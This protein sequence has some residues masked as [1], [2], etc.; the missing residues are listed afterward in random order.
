M[1]MKI[2]EETLRWFNGDELRARVFYEKYALRDY[3]GNVVEKIPPEMWKRVAREIASVELPE[4]RQDWE[5]KFYSILENF[6]FVPGGRIMFG[7]GNPRRSTLLNCYYIPIKEDSIEGIFECAKEMARTY[8][9]G[10]G[11]GCVAKD[12]YVVTRSGLKNIEKVLEGEEVLSFDPKLH[13][14]EFRKVIKTHRVIVKKEDNVK[15]KL[16]D[17]TELVTSRWH[18]TLVFRDGKFVYVPAEEV[19]IGDMMLRTPKIHNFPINV[20]YHNP[21]LGWIAGAYISDMHSIEAKTKKKINYSSLQSRYAYKTTGMGIQT[22]VPYDVHQWKN[23]NH[24][25]SYREDANYV[26]IVSN[27]TLELGAV[28]LPEW[29]FSSSY[30]TQIAFI[31]GVVDS[32]GKV[33]NSGIEIY[34]SDKSLAYDLKLLIS[35]L[36]GYADILEA[37]DQNHHA[38][39]SYRIRIKSSEFILKVSKYMKH[40]QKALNIQDILNNAEQNYVYVPKFIKKFILS[41]LT[42]NKDI[43]KILSSDY[44]GKQEFEKII[45]ALISENTNKSIDLYYTVLKYRELCLSLVQVENIQ[46]AVN[47]DEEFCDLTVEKNNNYF[48]GVGGLS[49]IHN[50][51]ISILRPKGSPVNNSAIYSTGA[52]SFMDLFSKVTGT[53]GQCLAKGT[54]VLTS[55]GWK[56]IEDI[57]VGDKVWTNKGWKKVSYVFEKRKTKLYKVTTNYGYTITASKDHK[58][59]DENFKL[60]PLGE[61]KEGD[62]VTMIVGCGTDVKTYPKLKATSTN[63]TG[64]LEYGRCSVK[65]PKILDTRL[66]YWLGFFSGA[67]SLE[68]D[69]KINF[70]FS[71]NR[72]DHI[73]IKNNLLKVTK[74]LFGI[75]PVEK[76]DGNIC[77]LEIQSLVICSFLKSNFALDDRIL[78]GIENSPDEN[79]CSFIAGLF[80]AVGNILDSKYCFNAVSERLG[81]DLH[82]N[83]L[84]LGV[85]SI[86]RASGI[87]QN[88]NKIFSVSV[89]DD[90]FIERFTNIIGRFSL[91]I[92]EYILKTRKDAI[93]RTN[94]SGYLDVPSH[95]MVDSW[96]LG[97]IWPDGGVKIEQ[98][99]LFFQKIEKIEFSG[100]EEAYDIEVEDEHKFCA[101]GFYVSNSGRRGALMITIEDRH[102]DVFDFIDVKDDPLRINVRYANISVKVSD[103]LMKAVKSDGVFTLWFESEKVRRIEM[104]IRARELWQ[105]LIRR[106]WSSAEPGVIFWD[107]AKRFS[108]TEYDEKMAVKGCNPCSEQMLEDYGCCNLGNINLARLVKNPFKKEIDVER[109]WKEFDKKGTKGAIEY[110]ERYGMA[111]PD[112]IE[113]ERIIRI[114]IRFLDNVLDYSAPRHP[115]KMQSEASLYSRRVGLGA[116]GLGDM[117]VELMLKY[118]SSDAIY[119]MDKLFEFIKNIAYDESSEIAREKGS[120]PAFRV[121]KHLDQPFL[122]GVKDNVKEKI[123]AQGLRNSC[124]LT[125]PPVGSGAILAG[126][127]GGI[128][129]IFAL[130]YIRRSE[131]LSKETFKVFHPLVALYLEI[132][133]GK[134]ERDLPDFFVTAHQIEPKMRVKIQGTIQK[135]I[136]SSISSTVNLPKNTTVEEIGKIYELAWEEGCKGITVYREGSREGVLITESEAESKDSISIQDILPSEC[137]DC[138]GAMRRK[139]SY[140]VCNSCGALIK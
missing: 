104:K 3:D 20:M 2:P 85:A 10:G 33:T 78:S 49:V 52:V 90:E 24:S 11:V 13:E 121:D 1:E 44:I 116:T 129:P 60:K 71:L 70:I 29:I 106:A 40:N 21:E 128:E 137:P 4:K 76:I 89:V 74:E 112:L 68:S 36:G 109:F 42:N 101:E 99:L 9:F 39:S 51:D 98:D 124:L 38:N 120:F 125:I 23:I 59:L 62:K 79:I 87:S 28:K 84:R 8:S 123:V 34:I 126:T 18:P 72:K 139:N 56:N 86:F 32:A 16:K 26:D 82:R 73:K 95:L 127:T 45:D 130:S 80:D 91:R 69:G 58:F 108:P 35:I 22:A 122:K 132:T 55:E 30:E 114:A 61:F 31:A 54:Q 88:Y 83:L 37:P 103:K 64:R 110:A 100:D 15:V 7:A 27:A 25:Y 77:R 67:G 66:A 131:S 63:E 5:A 140:S 115:L 57:K 53:I 75:V 136:D 12:H 111:H 138:G 133:G 107:T 48:A 92:R 43:E 118:D 19:G 47:V 6:K 102:P 94:I 119:M 50:T 97:N 41:N 65:Q 134:D 93:G 14:I 17:G 113:L 105:R 81:K 96:Y 135:H 117:L 46:K